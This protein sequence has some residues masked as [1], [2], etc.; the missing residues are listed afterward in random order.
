MPR[1]GRHG[2]RDHYTQIAKADASHWVEAAGEGDHYKLAFDQANTW[3]QK[4]NLVWDKILGLNVFPSNVA[5]TEVAY[6]KSHLDPYGLRLISTRTVTKT[7]WTYYSATLADNIADFEDAHRPNLRLFR[8]D[9]DARSVA[10]SYDVMDVHSGGMH[11]RPVG[12][13]VLRKDAD[14]PRNV[15]QMV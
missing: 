4:Y 14:R 2:G 6:Y 1:D 3:S 12:W 8:P 5:K 11:A 7:D 9:D 15:G 13:R 10:D